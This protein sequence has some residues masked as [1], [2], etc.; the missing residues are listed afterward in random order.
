MDDYEYLKKVVPT[1]ITFRRRHDHLL[2][3]TTGDGV[4]TWEFELTVE[5]S[6]QISELT[7]PVYV[8]L[9]SR[10]VRD[11]AI[12]V[13]SV[14]V[15]GQSRDRSG[16]YRLIEE[17]IPQDRPPGEPETIQYAHLKV[18]VSLEPDQNSCT[19]EMTLRLLNSFPHA[20]TMA[21]L[22]VDI[23]YV[24]EQL[25]VEIAAEHHP[26]RLPPLERTEIVGAM[27]SLMHMPDQRESTLQSLSCEERAGT[28]IW[29]TDSAKLGYHYKLYFQLAE[30]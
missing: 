26:V 6:H 18:P 17:R 29:T 25:Q 12:F 15:D 21:S 2:V 9:A 7:F 24:T 20:K 27:S 13:D 10:G 3:N 8:E 5:P 4:L 23:P 16:V 19:V 1:L 28:I 30:I 14:K 11:R 22:F